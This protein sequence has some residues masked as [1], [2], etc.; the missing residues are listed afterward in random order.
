LYGVASNLLEH[1]A[2]KTLQLDAEA[3]FG[4]E[5]VFTAGGADKLAWVNGWRELPHVDREIAKLYAY[6]QTFA[7][8]IFERVEQALRKGARADH[9]ATP[10]ARTGRL[11]APIREEREA[12]PS[13]LAVADLPIEY[14]LS[15]DKE[16]AAAGKAEFRDETELLSDRQ[17]GHFVV[18]YPTHGG[19]VAISKDL[20]TEVLGAG[21]DA[22]IVGL[23]SA[24]VETLR[25]MCRGLVA[26]ASR[27]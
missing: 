27:Q 19:W 14:V 11:F 23:P 24:A 6:P 17:E 4:L 7:A 16:M 18:C 21:R 8:Q 2:L 25:L 5:D 20:L 15:S 10:V 12:D 3:R 22:K 1:M 13:V 9:G 26:H